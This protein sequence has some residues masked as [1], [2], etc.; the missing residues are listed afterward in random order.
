MSEELEP[1]SSMFTFGMKDYLVFG[2]IQHESTRN[3]LIT[4]K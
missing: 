1:E 3:S 2:L 4:E